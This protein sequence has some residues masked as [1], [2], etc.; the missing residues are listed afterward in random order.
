MAP[1]KPPAAVK[2]VVPSEVIPLLIP[3]MDD[4]SSPSKYSVKS[5]G[6]IVLI[7][8]TP[9]PKTREQANKPIID[10]FQKAGIT[11]PKVTRATPNSTSFFLEMFIAIRPA[12]KVISKDPKPGRVVNSWIVE[13]GVFG[14][15]LA[16]A[17]IAEPAI[18]PDI[19]SVAMLTTPI[20][21]FILFIM[22]NPFSATSGFS[23]NF[24]LNHI[25]QK[26]LALYPN[27]SRTISISQIADQIEAPIIAKNIDLSV[28]KSKEK[29]L[30][31]D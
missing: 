22:F 18:P 9:I 8:P 5:I 11:P 15:D 12:I 21:V 3:I 1:K 27:F 25:I 10:P 19:A 24:L 31:F 17:A 26:A 29:L 30:Q 2:M 16:I 20:L 6:L 14:N 4:R 23:S 28:F 7:K 13:I